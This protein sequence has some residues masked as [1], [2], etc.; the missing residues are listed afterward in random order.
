MKP[1]LKPNAN[2]PRVLIVGAG[3]AGATSALLLAERGIDVTLIEREPDFERVFRGEAL[4]P[5]GMEALEQM[6]L[7]EM[8]DTLPSRLIRSWDMY[9]A[10]RRTIQVFEP[11]EELGDRAVR[12]VSQPAFLRT[13]VAKAQCYPSFKLMMNTSVRNLVEVDGRVIGLTVDTPNGQEMLHADY[14]IGCDGRGS[15]LRTRANIQLNLLPESYDLLWFRFPA[16]PQLHDTTD[17]MLL[18][19]MKH[20]ALCYNSFDNHMRYALLL[21]KG[22]YGK[23]GDVNWVEELTEPVPMWLAEHIRQ[24]Q[25]QIEKPI[26]LNV[27]V[28]RAEQWS[29]PGLLLL[30]DAAHP[31]SPVRAQGINLALRDVIVMVN[32]LVPAL[33][34]DA[35]PGALDA[36][37]VAI[38]AERLP[39]IERAQT[40]QLREARGQA[41]ERLRPILIN[42]AKWT[43][44]LFARFTWAQNAWLQQQ[45]DL[46]FGS[47]K[48]ALQV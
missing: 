3:P 20:T 27:I 16:P 46:R 12:V 26:R 17:V 30:G 29:V 42:L 35:E 5:L 15:V 6:G 8:L 2:T 33:Y 48:V 10:N 41:N 43:A 38:Q 9:V 32:H 24:V 28:G 13:V 45:K 1:N 37:A 11:H 47:A 22:K 4:M 34:S 36:A 14:V 25:A 31:M 23:T 19:S 18:G 40:L 44:P 39:E 7:A 21:P